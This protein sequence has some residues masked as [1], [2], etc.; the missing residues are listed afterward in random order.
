MKV[1]DYRWFALLSF[2]MALIL[3]SACAL[4]LRRPTKRVLRVPPGLDSTT[5]VQA[6]RLANEN[7]VSARREN[8]ARKHAE[9]GKKSL[10]R[11]DDFWAYLEQRVER[12][13]MSASE[14]A[15][16]DREMAKGAQALQRW[17]AL[18]KNGTDERAFQRALQ[19][20]LKAQQHLE[21]AVRLNPFDK[22]A[23]LLLAVTYYN[24]QNIFGQDQNFKKAVEILERLT[25]IEKG[26]HDL[27]RLLA[28]NYMQLK[29]YR[30]A[31]ENFAR[32]ETVLIKTSF[33]APPDTATLFYYAYMQGDMYARLY[34][35]PAAVK[36]FA[37]A[38]TYARTEQERKDVENY[39]AWIN[40]DG[41]NI[42]ASEVWD[43]ILALEAKKSYDRMARLC[44]KLL[45]KLQ[46]KKAK[47][48][49]HHKLAVVEFEFLNRKETAVERM[50]A[51]YEALGAVAQSR[52]RPPEVQQYL[53]TYGA[54]LYRMG[55]DALERQQK[56]LAL[57][58]FTK[59]IEFDWNQVAK[60]YVEMV[61][62]LWNSPEKAIYFGEKALAHAEGALSSRESCE[63][64]SLM[65]KAHKS[66]GLYDKARD[67]FQQWKQC[68]MEN[69]VGSE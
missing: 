33:E 49:V 44:K 1:R 25:R 12:N 34:N 41:G 69:N 52:N 4:P 2:G 35:A 59:S 65:V 50:K 54:M 38:K 6:N 17:K 5:V 9:V 3:L 62:L 53:D 45:P 18:T 10:K 51:V 24:L 29:D 48:A 23:R 55:V 31:L 20:C 61:T 68:R 19:Y 40:W 56:K 26:E 14:Q 67:Y 36:K 42:R 39:L 8:E 16:F 63:L 37:M 43:E 32:A 47:L 27:F 64:L 66:A 28:E 22:N 60:S 58:Y 11:V 15:Q 57:A 21:T 30:R 46:T 7:F 13:P